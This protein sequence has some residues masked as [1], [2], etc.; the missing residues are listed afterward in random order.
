MKYFLEDTDDDKDNDFGNLWTVFDNFDKTLAKY[1]IDTVACVQRSI[2]VQVKDS[3][4]KIMEK[5]GTVFDVVIEGISRT[6]WMLN[7]ISETAI[8]DAINVAKQEKDCDRSFPTC[9]VNLKFFYSSIQ[10]LMHNVM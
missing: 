10:K 8:E 9:S 2:C 3:R 6:D 5:T 7:F 4:Q 1:N